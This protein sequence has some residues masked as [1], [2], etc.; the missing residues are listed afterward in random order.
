MDRITDKPDWETRIFDDEIAAS[1]KGEAMAAE[2]LMSRK[3]WE[4]CLEE[5]RYK[6]KGF[7]PRLAVWQYTT[8]DQGIVKSRLAHC[9]RLKDLVQHVIDRTDHGEGGQL[10]KDNQ[11]LDIV[12]PSFYPL[13]YGDHRG[14]S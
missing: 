13:A 3:A 5:L 7:T 14:V 11:V 2:V 8:L 4:W 1:W 9:G 10:N 12:N 6:A